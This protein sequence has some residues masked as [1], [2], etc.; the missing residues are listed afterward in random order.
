MPTIAR[1]NRLMVAGSGIRLSEIATPVAAP[2]AFVAVAVQEYRTPLPFGPRLEPAGFQENAPCGVNVA[3]WAGVPA[4][5][6]K[7]LQ[8]GLLDAKSCAVIVV[9]CRTSP[10]F[11]GVITGGFVVPPPTWIEPTAPPVPNA[12]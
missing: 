4:V 12:S 3:A 7:A 9:A 1:P 11:T 2:S 6:V 10:K 5:G 8:V